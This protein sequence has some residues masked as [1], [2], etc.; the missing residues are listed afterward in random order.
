M[1][2]VRKSKLMSR[3]S[4]VLAVLVGLAAILAIFGI[5]GIS[6][7][8][9]S[10]LC[11]SSYNSCRFDCGALVALRARASC[12][13]ICVSDYKDCAPPGVYA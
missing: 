8:I 9:S 1:Q 2:A 7:D 12:T 13:S 4:M 5:A 3:P 6:N 11:M 10:D